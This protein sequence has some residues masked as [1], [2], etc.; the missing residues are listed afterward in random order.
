MFKKPDKLNESLSALD[1]TKWPSG[2]VLGVNKPDNV[3]L[4]IPRIPTA[5]FD[6]DLAA[7]G[8]MPLWR[9]NRIKGPEDGGKSTTAITMMKTLSMWCFGCMRYVD[10]CECDHGPYTLKSAYCDVENKFEKS[11]ARRLGVSDDAYYLPFV[12]KS[13]H[14]FDAAEALLR[15]D[16]CGLVIVDSL[17]MI[18]PSSEYD[19]STE[20]HQ[21]GSQARIITK[22]V[23]EISY[24]LGAEQRRDHP[25]TIIVVNQ[26]RKNIGGY[27]NP[28]TEGGGH[29]AK[30]AIG[31]GVRIR[32]SLPDT[33]MFKSGD[34][35]KSVLNSGVEKPMAIGYV[36]AFDKDHL[37]TF[38]KGFKFLRAVE[39]IYSKTDED[40]LLYPAGTVIDYKKSMAVGIELGYIQ[41]E[42]NKPKVICR[43]TEFENRK[44]LREAWIE[45]PQFY[46]TCQL[47]MIELVK[48]VK[49]PCRM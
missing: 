22:A 30:H 7:L 14:W 11:W 32:K 39:D 5:I 3:I 45:H 15:S 4:N 6:F 42:D 47:E 44:R 31:L 21:P 48:G 41:K 20:E 13:G 23:Q 49:S 19:R 40:Q 27:G 17:G 35:K 8:G 25:C 2:F 29:A 10:F 33:K 9:F 34:S 43:G 16:E 26:I 24:R 28:E 38:K 1:G 18:L 36:G 46:Y 12:E 37:T